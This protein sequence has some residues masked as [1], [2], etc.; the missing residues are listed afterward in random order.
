MLGYC[1]VCINNFISIHQI[2]EVRFKLFS[3]WRF[4]D[5]IISHG[6][7]F[8]SLLSRLFFLPSSNGSVDQNHLVSSKW[9]HDII[10]ITVF[11]HLERV[12]HRSL[13]KVSLSESPAFIPAALEYE[14]TDTGIPF[15]GLG[16]DMVHLPR[17][18]IP[19]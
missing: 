19:L 10:A 7:H 14:M 8:I 9:A 18:V 1:T 6:H 2:I 4:H 13:G 15:P 11:H 17:D 5:T 12:I 16:I 3:F